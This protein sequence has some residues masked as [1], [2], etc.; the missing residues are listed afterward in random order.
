LHCKEF[1]KS[2]EMIVEYK[3]TSLKICV[4]AEG[5]KLT[6]STHTIVGY[7]CNCWAHGT[8]CCLANAAKEFDTSTLQKI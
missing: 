7:K 6:S 8:P 3:D 1:D 4:K 5:G 2:F